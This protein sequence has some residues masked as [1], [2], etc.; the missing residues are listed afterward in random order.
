MTA[1]NLASTAYSARDMEYHLVIGRNR[2]PAAFTARLKRRA[3]VGRRV[4]LYGPI[5]HFYKKSALRG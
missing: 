2:H 3:V 1:T 5:S 4:P